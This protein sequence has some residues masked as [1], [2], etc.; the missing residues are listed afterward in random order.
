MTIT[1]FGAELPL[2]APGKLLRRED[3]EVGLSQA[4]V[5]RS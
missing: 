3:V 5:G 1:H 4:Q 2:I